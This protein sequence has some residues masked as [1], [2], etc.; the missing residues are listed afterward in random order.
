MHIRR[1]TIALPPRLKAT[2]HRDAR[3]IAEALAE[4]LGPDSGGAVSVELQG[5]GHSGPVLA[6]QVAAKMP[7]SGGQG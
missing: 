2:A 6:Q 1:L 5:N 3:L 7:K 4:R